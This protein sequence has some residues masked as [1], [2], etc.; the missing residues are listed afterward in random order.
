VTLMRIADA[1]GDPPFG[2]LRRLSSFSFSIFVSWIIGRCSTASWSR[3]TIRRLLLFTADLLLSFWAQHI[4]TK[5]EYVIYWRFAEWVRR[6]A[7]LHFFVL[8]VSFASFCLIV[9]MLSLKLQI[10]ETLRF[11]SDIETKH[12]FEDAISMKF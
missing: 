3:S 10:P 2:L 1:F 11:S 6:F 8:L 12:A 5:G 7:D 9:S 4:G